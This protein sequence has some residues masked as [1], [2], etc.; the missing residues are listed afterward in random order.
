M[1]EYR[2]GFSQNCVFIDES[3]FYI[4]MKKTNAWS[5]KGTTSIVTVPKTKAISHTI[6]GAISVYAVV[7]IDVKEP[8]KPQIGKKKRKVANGKG[9]STSTGRTGTTS[10]INLDNQPRQSTSTTISDNQP[11]Q[12]RWIKW[13]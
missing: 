9:K 2:Y 11:R 7:K 4:N 1:D 10:T 6:I 12:G 8:N 13:L 5:A 3:E